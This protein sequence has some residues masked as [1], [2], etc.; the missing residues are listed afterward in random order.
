MLPEGRCAVLALLDYEVKAVDVNVSLR[1]QMLNYRIRVTSDGQPGLHALRV[2]FVNPD[3]D[4]V[5][6]Y[7]T[8]LRAVQGQATGVF[9]LALNDAPGEWTVRVTDVLSG[10]QGEAKFTLK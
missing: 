8:T 3:G 4:P 5:A 9:N 2:E 7:T 6:H 10:A 1:P